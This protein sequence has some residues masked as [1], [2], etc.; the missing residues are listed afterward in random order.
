MAQLPPSNM[1]KSMEKSNEFQNTPSIFYM[2]CPIAD[3]FVICL[4]TAI[5]YFVYNLEDDSFQL[6]FYTR[7]PFDWRTPFGFLFAVAVE[8]I[9][10]ECSQMWI[11]ATNCFFNGIKRLSIAFAKDIMSD[12]QLLNVHEASKQSR[13]ELIGRFCKIV[14][15]YSDA[16]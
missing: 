7:W 15:F 14:N 8:L 4:Q 2:A 11:L 13:T 9:A 1:P 6:K 3:C 10:W 5:K 16:R 12:L